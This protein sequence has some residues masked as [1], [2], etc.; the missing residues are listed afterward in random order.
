MRAKQLQKLQPALSSG[1]LM[2][3]SMDSSN[4]ITSVYSIQLNV[5]TV[6]KQLMQNFHQKIRQ[7]A[8]VRPQIG[9]LGQ[10]NTSNF[11]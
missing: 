8:A 2:H 5:P 7:E 4:V 10:F 11:G 6:K 1:F 9:K 3:G